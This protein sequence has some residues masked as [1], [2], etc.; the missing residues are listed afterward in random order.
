[1]WQPELCYAGAMA[2]D[3]G[4][5]Y[6]QMLGPGTEGRGQVMAKELRVPGGGGGAAGPEAIR[7]R[8]G[9]GGTESSRISREGTPTWAP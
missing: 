7:L 6:E 2:E 8:G 3:S 1:M 4:M 5:T 9:L